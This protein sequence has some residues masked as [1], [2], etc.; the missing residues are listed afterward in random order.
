LNGRKGPLLDV[1]NLTTI[2]IVNNKITAIVIIIKVED[3]LKKVFVC[4]VSMFVQV[5]DNNL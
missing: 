3:L 2:I 4:N 5:Y 1:V